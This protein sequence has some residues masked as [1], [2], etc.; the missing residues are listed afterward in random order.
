MTNNKTFALWVCS[1]ATFL[2]SGCSDS[3]SVQSR[4]VKNV[5]DADVQHKVAMP[6]PNDEN[7]IHKLHNWMTEYLKTAESA[8]LTACPREFHDAYLKHVF[9]WKNA[10]RY[11]A[12]LAQ[13]DVGYWGAMWMLVSG[14][15]LM[16][17]AE[18]SRLNDRIQTTWH[19]VELS[20]LRHGVE[21]DDCRIT[22][23]PEMKE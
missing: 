8:D 16:I 20:A 21:V 4:A 3:A 15:G 22:P 9:E 10:E 12:E 5:I 7:G 17:Q 23:F 6:S 2:F 13:R 11:V 18:L 14:E 19:A 1:T